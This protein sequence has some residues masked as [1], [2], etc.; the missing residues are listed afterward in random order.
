MKLMKITIALG[1]LLISTGSLA[2]DLTAG[3]LK[4]E[5]KALKTDNSEKGPVNTIKAGIRSREGKDVLVTQS[6]D[7]CTPMMMYKV[8]DLSKKL[9]RPVFLNGFGIFAIAYD[10]N[11]FVVA[12][13]DTPSALIGRDRIT[14]F[15][16]LN[17]YSKSGMPLNEAQAK[18]FVIEESNKL[19]A[20]K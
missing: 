15:K 17:V 8:A 5:F 14:G 7:S 10:T 2:F 11:S 16:F 3:D 18:K 20:N 12:M 19:L 1:A 6:C 4:G 9:D 13:P